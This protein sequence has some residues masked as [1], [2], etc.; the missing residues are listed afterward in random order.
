MAFQIVEQLNAQ[1]AEKPVPASD[2]TDWI[3]Q[4]LVRT[5]DFSAKAE[6]AEQFLVQL[7]TVGPTRTSS[8]V[9]W[10]ERPS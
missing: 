2:L 5:V 9:A 3:W 10:P 1:Q 6:Q 4:G 7:I 8:R